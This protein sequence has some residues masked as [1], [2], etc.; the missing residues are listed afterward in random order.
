MELLAIGNSNWDYFY[1]KER[2]VIYYISKKLGCNNGFFCS[3]SNLKCHL[4]RL[5]F[6]QR[7]DSL[8]PRDWNVVNDKLFNSLTK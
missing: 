1:D 8:I 3:G 5:A 4:K 2:N 6:I 7:N